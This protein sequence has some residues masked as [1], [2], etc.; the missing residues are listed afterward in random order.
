[1]GA[2]TTR[3][4]IEARYYATPGA[5]TDLQRHASLVRLFPGT[6][7][8]AGRW[9]RNL[10][11]HVNQLAGAA[12]LDPDR[13]DELNTRSAAQMIDKVMARSQA[14]LD[15][16][17]PPEEQIA[18]NCHHGVVIACALLRH[19]SVPAR[20]RYGF[21]P[22]LKAGTYEDHCICEVM[23]G[24]TWQ[25]FDPRYALEVDDPEPTTFLTGGA[26]WLACRQAAADPS[27]FGSDDLFGDGEQRGWWFLLNNVVRDY[28]ALCKVELH[29][30]DWWGLMT[31]DASDRPFELIDEIAALTVD[32][33]CWAARA[34]R[35]DRDPK[36]NPGD[37]VTAFTEH[38]QV[39]NIVLPDRW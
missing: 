19:A 17:R 35:F 21:A 2:V 20:L 11:V 7:S 5:T 27:L 39:L 9:A 23:I 10:V 28:A 31:A 1:M 8:E 29:P 33:A 12:D 22:Y 4:R 26:A 25:R 24:R 13:D 38:G 32:D 18:G 30:W 6:P 36:L 37:G 3:A 34:D 15:Q 16:A 14:A